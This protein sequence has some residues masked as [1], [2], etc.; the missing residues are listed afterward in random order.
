MS[1]SILS[2]SRCV[3]HILPTNISAYADFAHLS[4]TFQLHNP[5]L[6]TPL[7]IEAYRNAT[8]SA[9]QHRNNVIAWLDRLQS[10]AHP[11]PQKNP[12][13]LDTR[14]DKGSTLSDESDREEASKKRIQSHP[15]H[16]LPAWEHTPASSGTL[17]GS[18]IDPYPISAAP[19][20]LLASF[21][22]NPLGDAIVS[23]TDTTDETHEKNATWDDDDVVRLYFFCVY[24]YLREET[25]LILDRVLPERLISCLGRH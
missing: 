2:S 6:A 14:A 5:Y 11:S 9:D 20:G 3:P 10:Q 16:G 17:I 15:S 4:R 21:T 7:S 18:D 13:Q 1:L 25:A 23:T 8:P 19:I 22:V 24:L 12:F